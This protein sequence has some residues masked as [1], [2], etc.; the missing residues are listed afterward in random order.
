MMKSNYLSNIK[1][2]KIQSFRNPS[3]FQK[4]ISKINRLNCTISIDFTKDSLRTFMSHL[5]IDKGDDLSPKSLSKSTKSNRSNVV[6]KGYL[7][8]SF[9]GQMD[10]VFCVNCT[11][12]MILYVNILGQVYKS[13][14]T[15]ANEKIGH[16]NPKS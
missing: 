8:E 4:E 6:Q 9:Q 2:N 1:V 5:L 12:S 16:L 10:I 7:Q 13:L 11:K 15:F 3:L 14:S